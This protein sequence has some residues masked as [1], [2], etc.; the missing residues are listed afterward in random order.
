MPAARRRAICRDAAERPRVCQERRFPDL[1]FRHRLPRADVARRHVPRAGGQ[2][3]RRAHRQGEFRAPRLARSIW[4]TVSTRIKNWMQALAPILPTAPC[5]A[6]E[7]RFRIVA[8]G[9]HFTN[10]IR[11]TRTR[12]TVRRR[13]DRRAHH[14][15]Q[16]RWGWG[17]E[18]R[19]VFG[20]HRS[21]AARARRHRVRHGGQP[22]G[23]LV[24]SDK[25]FVLTPNGDMRVLLDEGTRE[26]RR[27]G[28]GVLQQHRDRRGAV[29]HRA[30]S[31]RGWRASRSAARISKR[32]TSGR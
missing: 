20:P 25:L 5:P 14:A 29:C 12:S 2:H 3:R 26:G 13:N 22:R 10:E 16:D 32:Y 1:E 4:I 17:G 21:A 15:A 11:S 24:Y 28:A 19:E 7:R 23:T 30:R 9:F 31:R 8:D 6:G 27:T 18:G